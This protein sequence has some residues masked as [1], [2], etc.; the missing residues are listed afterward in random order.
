MVQQQRPQV[1]IQLGAT[2]TATAKQMPQVEHA[3][4]HAQATLGN[5]LRLAAAFQHF[6]PI[7]LEVSP[8]HLPFAQLHVA[9]PCGR[10]WPRGSW[11]A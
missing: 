2:A 10:E 9:R 8:A 6:L 5:D 3:L 4:W 1:I 11:P 7:P